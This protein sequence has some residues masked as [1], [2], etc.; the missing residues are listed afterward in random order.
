MALSACQ[1][2]MA[3]PSYGGSVTGM[4]R[5][6]RI[7]GAQTQVVSLWSVNDDSTRDL[8]ID[9]YHNLTK[10]LPVFEA[11]RQAQLVMLHGQDFS[12]RHPFYWA[13]FQSSGARANV[14]SLLAL[15]D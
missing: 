6:F 11:L 12:K 13:P 1:T 9:F 14:T 10:G 4:R 7:A 8:M 15:S 3:D 5:A 2:G